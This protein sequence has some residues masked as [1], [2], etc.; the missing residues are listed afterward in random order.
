MCKRNSIKSVK[1]FCKELEPAKL[2]K[3]IPELCSGMLVTVKSWNP[4][5][6]GMIDRS[7]KGDVLRIL[8]VDKDN[9]LCL[10]D[11]FDSP[12]KLKKNMVNFIRVNK[13]YA[14]LVLGR[15]WESFKAKAKAYMESYK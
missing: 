3:D 6:S 1:V 13:T 11:C 5:P 4:Y 2:T 8:H 12:I 7:F 9:V 14:K 15:N 10:V